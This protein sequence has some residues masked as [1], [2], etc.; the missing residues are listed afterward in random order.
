MAH[1]LGTNEAE[2]CFVVQCIEFL[3]Y[4]IRTFTLA[5]VIN[6]ANESIIFKLE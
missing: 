4:A 1:T 6:D 5:A 2:H 3:N